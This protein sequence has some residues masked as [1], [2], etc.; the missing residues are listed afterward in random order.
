LNKQK[1][2]SNI[3]NLVFHNGI[4]IIE[5][6]HWENI[7][8]VLREVN[9]LAA[10]FYR[11]EKE[12]KLTLLPPF[13]FKHMKAAAIYSS[14]QSEQVMFESKLLQNILDAESIP[15]VFLKGASYTLRKSKNS[16]GR[17]Y[18]DI[19]LLVTKNDISNAEKAL[20]KHAWRTKKL[21]EYDNNYFREWSHEIP[22][23]FNIHRGTV[24]DLHHNILL[25]ISGREVNVELL[26]ENCQKIEGGYTVLGYAA[27]IL[28][29]IV[30]LIIN[31]DVSN[32]YRDVLDITTLI[33]DNDSPEFWQE[34]TSLSSK[35]GFNNELYLALSL[36]TKY[37]SLTI[38]NDVWEALNKQ[39]NNS[40]LNFLLNH[41]YY[42]ALQPHSP[43]VQ[44]LKHKVSI[45][46]VYI[47]GHLQK[48]PLKILVPHLLT[49]SFFSI[50][51]QIF[52]KHH[53]DK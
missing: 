49:K 37:A 24:L 51:D 14:R 26:T 43:K 30:H 38:P 2:Y 53:F 19:D 18:S 22:P 52:G 12:D 44:T 45:S 20:A 35:L 9:L 21:S 4:P 15:A 42:F 28:H 13:A 11:L 39:R 27:T 23:M 40:K 41:V 34:I 32:G 50:R 46:I 10:C 8:H 48:M 1:I 29:S 33:K 31:E 17:V 3:E 6:K 5:L 47:L 36:S 16:E 25:P 7:I